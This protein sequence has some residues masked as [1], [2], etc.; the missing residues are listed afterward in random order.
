MNGNPWTQPEIDYLLE[1]A[2]DHPFP[3]L[4]RMYNRMA[5]NQGWPLRKPQGIRSAV[6]RYG[7]TTYAVG[8]WITVTQ[9]CHM[10]GGSN[11]LVDYWIEKGWIPCRSF[12][13]SAKC[14]RYISRS[15]L[16]RL[17]RERPHVFGGIDKATL[18]EVLCDERLAEHIA[19]NHPRRHSIPAP[20]IQV[21]T[22]RRFPSIKA[23]ARAT[24][25]T[26]QALQYALRTQKPI[27][28]FHWKLA[29][30]RHQEH[31]LAKA[32]AKAA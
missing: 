1:L 23:A 29:N 30:P 27:A 9:A 24:Y 5:G 15:D 32:Q 4:C 3:M 25:V 31:L 7:G 14:Y 18:N 20:V 21:E 13:K 6:Y 11:R 22:V 16:R 8:E 12:T 28:G 19:A 10:L 2:G 17:A 26:H